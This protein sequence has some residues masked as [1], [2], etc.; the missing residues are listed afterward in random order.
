MAFGILEPKDVSAHVPGTTLL[1]VHEQARADGSRVLKKGTGRNSH[2]VLVPQPSDDPNDPLV[3]VS[4]ASYQYH[5]PEVSHAD[6]S[7][8]WPLWRR[9]MLLVLLLWGIVV[10][11]CLVSSV[12]NSSVHTT[13]L[14]AICPL[15]VYFPQEVISDIALSYRWLWSHDESY[16]CAAHRSI[17]H[18][19]HE[20]LPPIR[21]LSARHGR[22]RHLY[23]RRYQKIRK[24]PYLD[25]VLTLRVCGLRMGRC[26]AVLRLIHGR[27]YNP[28]PQYGLL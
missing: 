14:S 16:R 3:C 20:V 23:R 13:N 26:G 24:T 5:F 15:M 21:I 1:D 10:G 2:V 7:Q 27:P 18:R 9:D 12:T 28:G 11:K 8:N 6:K 4:T 19:F 17:Q 25:C 22:H